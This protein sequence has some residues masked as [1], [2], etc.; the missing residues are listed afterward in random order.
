MTSRT[1]SVRAGMT[2]IINIFKMNISMLWSPA[3]WNTMP[4]YIDNQWWSLITKYDGLD[5]IFDLYVK[6][7][8][9][10]D[11]AV[12][13]NTYHI[14]YLEA[15]NIGSSY[16]ASY[17]WWVSTHSFLAWCLC[18]YSF[19]NECSQYVQ[20]YFCHLSSSNSMNISLLVIWKFATLNLHIP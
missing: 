2:T 4:S 8:Q 9:I 20:V 15:M 7:C 18:G 1:S 14:G 3:I 11:E 13:H 17:A 5:T 19:W 12:H 6:T 10:N 16:T